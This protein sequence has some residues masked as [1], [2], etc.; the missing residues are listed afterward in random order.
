M[1]NAKKRVIALHRRAGPG[2]PQQ[3]ATKKKLRVAAYC[4]VSSS[5]EEQLHS[6]ITQIKN[7]ERMIL[8]N[9]SWVLA[10]I[11]ADEGISGTQIQKRKA[12]LQ[13]ME[14]CR[15]ERIDLVLTKSVSRF[16]RNTVDCLKSVRELKALGVD[17]FI[18]TLQAQGELLLSVLMAV[19][20][21]ES[22]AMS[23]NIKW[24]L[25]RKYE[26]GSLRSVPCGKLLGYDKVDGELVINEPQAEI[27][28]RIYREFLGGHG[29]ARIARGLT[30]DGIPSEQGNAV[31]SLSSIRQILR[32]EKF[33]GDTMFQ[34]TFNIDPLTKKRA[35]NTGELHRYYLQESNP[36]IVDK[37]TWEC[38]QL[39]LARQ[40][41]YCEAHSIG[42]YHLSSE[43]HP[44][45]A[46]IICAT[47]GSTFM[48]LSS[49][50]VGEEGR[51]YWRCS[52][53]RGDHGTEIEAKT[54]TPPPHHTKPFTDK[55]SRHRAKHRKLPQER[56]MLCTD[57]QIPDGQ[58][59]QAF[60]DAW[61]QLV[62]YRPRYVSV[63]E[64]VALETSD[65]L[66]RYR[67]KEMARLLYNGQALGG[68]DYGLSLQVFDHIKVIPDGELGVIF[69][70][71]I[72]C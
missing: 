59:E 52:S 43:E 34:K 54:Y 69:L 61:N 8:R 11:Y 55:Y 4:R 10:G 57:I 2:N 7:Y 32:N 18:H 14:G 64:R 36:A 60:V 17:V 27:V 42:R 47:C 20:E 37:E 21:N 68:F 16:G 51:K 25:R 22:T 40:E 31:W 6:Y 15:A 62:C 12:F 1:P 66:L 24:G 33:K 13:M 48:L 56:Q 63:L 38:L 30:A 49:K 41:R 44:L 65:P 28:R 9:G 50:R 71:D 3:E 23:E 53:F 26:R 35:K 19:S 5:S 45:S 46:R 67:S 72:Q 29:V 70:S 58:P 39:E